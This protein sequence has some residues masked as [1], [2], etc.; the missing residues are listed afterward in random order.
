MFHKKLNVI[1]IYLNNS[2]CQIFVNDCITLNG[3]RTL[4]FHPILLKSK[5]WDPN[6]LLHWILAFS[7]VQGDPLIMVLFTFLKQL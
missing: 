4:S 1:S 5:I 7:E 2:A 6:N 3:S